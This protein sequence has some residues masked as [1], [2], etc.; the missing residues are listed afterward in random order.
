MFLLALLI[1]F[2]W[3][4]AMIFFIFLLD[5]GSVGLGFLREILPHWFGTSAFVV[6]FVMGFYFGSDRT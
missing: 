5:R 2:V 3:N 6:N 1:S 4:G